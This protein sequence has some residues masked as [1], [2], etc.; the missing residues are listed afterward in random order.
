MKHVYGIKSLFI[1]ALILLLLIII[2]KYVIGNAYVWAVFVLAAFVVNIRLYRSRYQ[3]VT[4]SGDTM[5][6]R[7]VVPF[8]KP[9]SIQLRGVDQIVVSG[10]NAF[11]FLLVIQ[12]GT[13]RRTYR[14]NIHASEVRDMVDELKPYVPAITLKGAALLL[15]TGKQTI[16]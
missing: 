2:A 12:G 7:P 8:R 9:A 14:L 3:L 16:A 13:D 11:S 15:N 6:L 4:L 5:V 1:S 10:A